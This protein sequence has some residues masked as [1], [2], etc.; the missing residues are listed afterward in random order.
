MSK[1]VAFSHPPKIGHWSRVLMNSG[2][3][4]WISI[5]KD[6]VLIKKSKIGLFGKIIF[7]QGPIE[8]IYAKLGLLDKKFTKDF[9]PDDMKSLILKSFTNA[10]LC[11]KNLEEL[12][13]I[14]SEIFK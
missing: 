6:G 4:C 7:K 10:A 3:P 12:E 8:E 2:E 11:C 9:C 1:V 14:L 5:A 13:N